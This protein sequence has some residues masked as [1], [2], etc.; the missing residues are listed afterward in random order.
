MKTSSRGFTLI[1]VMVV[2]TLTGMI[3]ALLLQMMTIMLRGYDQAGRIQSRLAIESMRYT[4]FRDSVGGLAA[5]LDEEFGFQ[6]SSAEFSG[7]TLTALQ[8][9]TGKL[10]GFRWSIR[11]SSRGQSLYYE[12]DNKAPL[13]M[14]S[15]S[16]TQLTF[17]YR[18]QSSGWLSEWPAADLPAGVLP[19]RVKLTLNDGQTNREV[20]AAVTNR[21]IGRYDYRDLVR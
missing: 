14:G 5:S 6:G 3:A 20:F 4:W 11:P 10:T 13:L 19:Y 8:N 9:S 12:E 15:W 16:G 2:L 18:G 17:S 21:R 1:E 7:Y